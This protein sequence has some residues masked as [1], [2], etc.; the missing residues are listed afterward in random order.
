MADARDDD[1]AEKQPEGAIEVD[2]LVAAPSTSSASG[3]ALSAATM[4]ADVL[5]PMADVGGTV[6][7]RGSLEQALN[8]AD[9]LFVGRVLGPSYLAAAA[10]GN[11]YANLASV[12][13]Q[14]VASA[15]YAACTDSIQRGAPSAA[16]E[17]LQRGLALLALAAAGTIAVL[18]VSGSVLV[19][20][21]GQEPELA[22]TAGGFTDG[23]RYGMLPLSLC[24]GLSQ[25]LWAQGVV[26]PA[27]LVDAVSNALNLSLNA[28]LV[29]VDGFLGAPLAT[30][31]SR[32][33]QLALL[34]GYVV[35]WR[36]HTVRG[37]W[38]GWSLRTSLQRGPVAALWAASLTATAFCALEV[39]PAELST[40]LAGHLDVPALDAHTVVLQT[41]LFLGLTLPSGLQAGVSE[42]IPML[43]ERGDGAGAR[44]TAVSAVCVCAIYNCIAGFV[45]LGMRGRVGAIFTN[46]T[47][48]AAEVA[49]VATIAAAYQLIDGCA[50]VLRGILRA[51]GHGSIITAVSTVG[52][53][54]IS[55]PV[56]GTLGV[57]KSW[58]LWGLWIGLLVG[59]A[60]TALVFIGLYHAIDFTALA[61][62]ATDDAD[63]VDGEEVGEECAL[64]EVTADAGEEVRR[65]PGA[66][67]SAGSS[68]LKTT[69]ARAN[70]A[71]VGSVL[72]ASSRGG[73]GAALCR[74]GQKSGDFRRRAEVTRSWARPPVI[75]AY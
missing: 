18:S 46:S 54:C 61:A 30:S 55:L 16:G 4:M 47:E 28:L 26:W 15:V 21:F 66:L 20:L 57:T 67:T 14:G 68:E 71:Q 64:V 33:L 7:L 19:R 44:R 48:V 63:S 34:V 70:G 25:F 72:M 9:I 41:V 59:Q 37:T 23:L 29:S 13:F 24:K 39:W 2:R 1:A 45:L 62:A 51:A 53:L 42:R 43:L 5:R 17:H 56:G 10:L 27:L 75:S 60:A 8:I 69:D 52:W 65:A 74:D 22:E 58:G 31:V 11:A 49:A 6:M 73:S 12:P 50:I 3:G 40:L 36:P 32:C 35:L 38:S